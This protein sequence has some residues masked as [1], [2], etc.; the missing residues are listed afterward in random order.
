MIHPLLLL[1][2]KFNSSVNSS[3]PVTVI[4]FEHDT[5]QNDFY[6]PLVSPSPPLFSSFVEK[7]IPPATQSAIYLY[8]FYRYHH[9]YIFFFCSHSFYFYFSPGIRIRSKYKH[10]LFFLSWYHVL[11]FFLNNKNKQKNPTHGVYKRRNRMRIQAT[12]AFTNEVETVFPVPININRYLNNTLR[13]C[14]DLEY[15]FFHRKWELTFVYV[16]MCNYQYS[17]EQEAP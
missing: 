3:R 8:W 15:F 10:L 13:T 2:L 4:I 1:I 7:W 9:F 17:W 16:Q 5:I 6:S 11:L 14:L 12:G